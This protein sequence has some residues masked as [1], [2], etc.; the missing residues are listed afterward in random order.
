LRKDRLL[1]LVVILV[2]IG[3]GYLNKENKESKSEKE[4]ITEKKEIKTLSSA[5]REGYELLIENGFL[6][7]EAE[8]NKAYVD[9]GYWN[10][11]MIDEKKG[12][13]F[14]LAIYCGN[15]RGNEL[16]YVTLYDLYSGKKLAKYNT[17]G[18]DV[19]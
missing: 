10:H 1:I 5:E 16:Y 11:L 17:W 4:T 12:F 9:Q 7:I 15:Q 13:T 2:V 6:R 3:I 19:Y 14:G 18:F 8:N